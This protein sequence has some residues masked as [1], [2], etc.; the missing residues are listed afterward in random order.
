[1]D[2]IYEWTCPECDKIIKSIYKKQFEY[3]KEQHINSHKK[4]VRKP[5]T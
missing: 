1:M 2:E 4:N 3:N 5:K